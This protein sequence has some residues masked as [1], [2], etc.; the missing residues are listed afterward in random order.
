M[1]D[2]TKGLLMQ[3]MAQFGI[4]GTEPEAIGNDNGL[5]F[6]NPAPEDELPPVGEF[7]MPPLGAM[8]PP[9]QPTT[10]ADGGPI[11]AAELAAWIRSQESGDELALD[12]A[13]AEGESC[14]C[15]GSGP[16]SEKE[17]NPAELPPPEDEFD[18][19]L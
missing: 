18:F 1:D 5:E 10:G 12:G 11:T 6:P 15:S 8:P 14:G 17:A 4:L 13:D 3:L 16:G 2:K 7:K 19:T 9:G